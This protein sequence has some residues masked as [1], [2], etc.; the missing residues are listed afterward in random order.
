MKGKKAARTGV[1]GP[2]STTHSPL[3]THH[4][5]FTTHQPEQLGNILGRLFAARGWGR[6]QD[7]LRLEETWAETVGSSLAGH[8]RVGGLRKG[9][10]EIIVDN[11]IL[12]QEL[13]HYQKR[14]LLEQLRQRLPDVSIHDLRFRAGVTN[15]EEK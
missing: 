10:L 7:R 12:L 13:A 8:T 15:S 14:R 4:S 9:T 6:Q 1:D 11:P 2:S 5:A 3:T